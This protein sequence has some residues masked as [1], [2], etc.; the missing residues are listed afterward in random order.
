MLTSEAA[1]SLIRQHFPQDGTEYAAQIAALSLTAY[2][3]ASAYVGLLG[4]LFA[5]LE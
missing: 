4:A 3:V 1:A 2:K 5:P